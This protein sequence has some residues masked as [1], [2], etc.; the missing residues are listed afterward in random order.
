MVT[1][2]RADFP[3]TMSLSGMRTENT[4]EKLNVHN[5]ALSGGTRSIVESATA[6][7]D[8]TMEKMTSGGMG[9]RLRNAAARRRLAFRRRRTQRRESERRVPAPPSETLTDETGF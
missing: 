6:R 5:G 1:V 3:Q 9:W 7:G 4:G 8:R 2:R